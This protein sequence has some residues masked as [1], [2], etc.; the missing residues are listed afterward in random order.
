MKSHLDTQDVR[1]L[2]V[3][4]G[5]GGHTAQMLNLLRMFKQ[6]YEIEYA[7]NDDD[8][9]S[10]K[11]VLGKTHAIRNPRPYGEKFLVKNLTR[12]TWDA[13]KTIAS[14]RPDAIISAGPG[15]S[16]PLFIFGKLYGAK[17]IYL[18]TWSRSRTKSR[19]GRYCYYLADLFFVQWPDMVKAYPKAIYAGRLS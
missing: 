7:V 12:C 10:G 8:L 6:R 17:C 16:I 3:V 5:S 13:W 2:L 19:S 14:V 15:M 9:L 18:E 11:K 1:R 4:L